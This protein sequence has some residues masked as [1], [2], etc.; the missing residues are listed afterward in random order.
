[1]RY[2]FITFLMISSICFSQIQYDS[3]N[4]LYYEK[5]NQIDLPQEEIKS[6]VNEWMALNF[7]DANNVIKMNSDSKI[8]TKGVFTITETVNSITITHPVNFDLITEFREGRYKVSFKNID[9]KYGDLTTMPMT[10]NFM[11]YEEFID[12]NQAI[13]KK[14]GNEKIMVKM[15]EKGKIDMTELYS[16]AVTRYKSNLNDIENS[17]TLMA[18]NIENTVKKKTEKSDW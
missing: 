9:I 3:D 7:K 13:A 6:I 16:Q 11:S 2:L 1:M 10:K 8:I 17:I 5:V 15:I 4:N 18:E 12:Y 14:M